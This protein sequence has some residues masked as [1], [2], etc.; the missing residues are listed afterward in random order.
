M[1]QSAFQT[2]F[3]SKNHHHY[4]DAIFPG[5]PSVTA[6]GRI[7]IISGGSRGIGLAIANAFG[8]ATALTIILMARDETNLKIAKC[9]LEEVCTKTKFFYWVGDITNAK[10]MTEM[11]DFI[12]KTLGEPHILVL[13]AGYLHSQTNELDVPDEEMNRSIDVNFKANVSLVQ[14][15]FDP[16]KQTSEPKIIINVSTVAAHMRQLNMSAYGGSTGAFVTWL[17]HVQFENQDGLRVHNFHPGIILTDLLKDRGVQ[18]QDW[19]WD[20]R[21]F[22]LIPILVAGLFCVKAALLTVV[23]R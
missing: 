16:L 10:S 6:V 3:T 7:V 18:P 9:K 21:Q 2:S 22:L 13:S 19:D 5:N 1:S 17:D 12:R 11:F 8:I 4:Y 20:K 14:K 15:F 23:P